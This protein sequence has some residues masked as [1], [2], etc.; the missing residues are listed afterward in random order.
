[1]EPNKSAIK[2]E[3]IEVEF[4]D[5]ILNKKHPCI[6]AKTVFSMEKYHLKTYESMTAKESA[7]TVLKDLEAYI[8]QYDFESNEFESF[9]AVFPKDTFNTEIAFEKT[10][11]S[12]LQQLHDLD[13]NDWDPVVSEDPNNANFSFSLKG[14]AFYIV[15]LH[16]NSSRLARQSPYPTIVFNLHWQFEKLREM[17]T[18]KRIKKRIRKR[19]KK[20]QG[21]INPVLK[22]FGNDTETKQYSGRQ[23]EQNWTC[24][25]HS[26]HQLV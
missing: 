8:N 11:W 24:P 16:H 9:I 21:T 22:D 26:K 6:M 18:Y 12:F 17:G 23:V 15:G 10:L 7:T 1:M 5:F 4:K 13:D 25:F 14:K 2:T 3:E 20:L 19:D